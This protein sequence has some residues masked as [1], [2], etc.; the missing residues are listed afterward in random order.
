MEVAV[1]WPG[2]TREMSWAV[3]RERWGGEGGGCKV[4]AAWAQGSM[5]LLSKSRLASSMAHVQAAR[6]QGRQL[7]R[8][9]GGAETAWMQGQREREEGEGGWESR[10]MGYARWN[11]SEAVDGSKGVL[12]HSCV[13]ASESA[14]GDWA[15]AK[16]RERDKAMAN[17]KARCIGHSK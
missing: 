10:A 13:M 4:R 11:G 7:E 5:T 16:W 15:Q 1:G 17:V 12:E 8:G 6:E 3:R 2:E 9:E 14:A